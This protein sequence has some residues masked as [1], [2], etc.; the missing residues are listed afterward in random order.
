MAASNLQN[1]L[2]ALVRAGLWERPVEIPTVDLSVQDWKDILAA[3]HS[4]TVDG[5]VWR[6]LDI[7]APSATGEGL[8]LPAQL[9]PAFANAVASI[10][11]RSARMEKAARGLFAGYEGKGLHPVLLKGLSVAA[12]YD[13]PELRE[14]GDI[15]LYFPQ[16]E[17]PKAA[18]KT[19]KAKAD[20]SYALQ[21]E[22][23]P[24]ELHPNVL[25]IERPSCARKA[26]VLIDKYGFVAGP[27]GLRT[28][29]PQTT[30]ILLNTHIL[31]H[32]LGYG[33]GLR[34]M[35]DYA[36]AAVALNYD[37]E[38]YRCDL[39]TLGLLKWTAVLENFCVRFLGMPES[40]CVCCSSDFDSEKLADSLLKMVLKGGNFGLD[41][42][43]GSGPLRTLAAFLSNLGFS[44]RLAPSEAFWTIVSL[45]KGRL[46]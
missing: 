10:E 31:K 22:G 16:D 7:M 1:I 33:I 28:T 20:G 45:V 35:C 41:A 6:G 21:F 8:E 27:Q 9:L 4:Q 5:L 24:V 30:M 2:F 37:R 42:R 34:Q 12:L 17:F 26:S 15:D 39:S 14:S 23:V 18:P 29:V 44:L 32:V 46:S 25:D 11:D 36:R 40:A 13:H 43:K 3:A 38:Q 19:V